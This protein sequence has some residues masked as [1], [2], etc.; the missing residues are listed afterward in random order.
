MIKQ[1]FVANHASYK[2]TNK[3]QD[4]HQ[5]LALVCK[6]RLEHI[7]LPTTPNIHTKPPNTRN[8]ALVTNLVETSNAFHAK[9]IENVNQHKLP[10]PYNT[11]LLANCHYCTLLRRCKLITNQITNYK[12]VSSYVLTN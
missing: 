11:C 3:W 5:T 10:N 7:P 12:S 9:H 4:P 8:R 2:T 1:D 6:N